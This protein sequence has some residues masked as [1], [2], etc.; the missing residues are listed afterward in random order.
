MK[1][2]NLL[3]DDVVLDLSLTTSTKLSNYNILLKMNKKALACKATRNLIALLN[4]FV[5]EQFGS[6][7][8]RSH[9]VVRNR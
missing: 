2:H 1:D 8:Q 5:S 3:A 4:H 7:R 6:R 9:I